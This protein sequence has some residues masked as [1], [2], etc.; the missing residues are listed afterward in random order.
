MGMYT[1]TESFYVDYLSFKARWI[2]DMLKP[3]PFSV[4]T[5]KLPHTLFWL[6]L[7]GSLDVRIEGKQ[8]TAGPGDLVIIHP[9]TLFSLGEVEPGK[10]IHYL[11]LCAELKIGNLDMV[12]LFGL[13]SLTAH[14]ESPMLPSLITMWKQM[15][16]TFEELGKLIGEKEPAKTT[17][18]EHV[19]LCHTDISMQFLGLQA[20]LYQWLHHIFS[21]MRSF[22][23]DQP[24]QFDH[25]VMKACDYIQHHIDKPIY[26]DDLAKHVH[27]S[28]SH[29]SHLFYKSLGLYPM[30][31]VQ[32]TKIH[33]AKKML[34]ETSYS[35]KEIAN[36]IGY[37]EQSQLSRAFR[38]EEGLSPLHYRKLLA[39]SIAD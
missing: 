31:Y 25:R 21:I 32:R 26:L 22:L 12:G 4:D 28:P 9:N 7:D 8:I 39:N 27:L 10:C 19:Y 15:V 14:S 6:V 23:P 3:A 37:A 17:G 29:M 13:P 1:L 20:L 33:A 5:R 34:M 18:G 35:V 2:R 24:L 11:S 38:K 30:E 36:R 16:D